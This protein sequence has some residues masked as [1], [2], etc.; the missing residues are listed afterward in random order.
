MAF[1]KKGKSNFL[2]I[3]PQGLTCQSE[4]DCLTGQ[5]C[6]SVN[7]AACVSGQ[8]SSNCNCCGEDTWC[9]DQNPDINVCCGSDGACYQVSGSCSVCGCPSGGYC[10]PDGVCRTTCSGCYSPQGS[11]CVFMCTSTNPC[12]FGS[13]CS[14]GCCQAR[15]CVNACYCKGCPSCQVCTDSGCQTCASLGKCCGSDGKCYAQGDCRCTGCS[16]GY[17][18]TNGSCVC[19]SCCCGIE[20][21]AGTLCT[22]DCKCC[23]STGTDRDTDCQTCG[24]PCHQTCLTYSGV[25]ACYPDTSCRVTGCPSNECCEGSSGTCQVD[26]TCT[27][28]S[29]VVGTALEKDM[30]T[31]VLFGEII[32]FH[33]SIPKHYIH[34]YFSHSEEIANALAGDSD[35]RLMARGIIERYKIIIDGIVNNDLPPGQLNRVITPGDIQ[36]LQLYL[37]KFASRPNQD[38]TLTNV[39]MELYGK[40]PQYEGAT[41]GD[42]LNSLGIIVNTKH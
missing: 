1:P 19:N 3:L 42:I 13:C 29:A 15:G 7:S 34:L 31:F 4:S 30:R 39:I 6:S 12:C 32:R 37:S 28:E 22:C 10:Y 26:C 11:K 41:I 35:L 36:T 40:L 14:T 27:C 33:S 18:C 38:P 2:R 24:C 25:D 21:P 17:V 20:C 16:V 9:T 8:C 5:C 23:A